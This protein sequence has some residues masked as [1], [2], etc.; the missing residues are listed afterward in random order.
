MV[1]VIGILIFEMP[2]GK[3]GSNTVIGNSSYYHIITQLTLGDVGFIFPDHPAIY[4]LGDIILIEQPYY[5]YLK[6]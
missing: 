1:G 5:H 2:G 4:V 6:F 3:Q